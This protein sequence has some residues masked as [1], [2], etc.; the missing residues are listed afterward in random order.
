MVESTPLVDPL[1]SEPTEPT[2]SQTNNSS[3][4]YPT[5]AADLLSWDYVGTIA[6]KMKKKKKAKKA[7]VKD[8]W[9]EPV[10]NFAYEVDRPLYK[11]GPNWAFK[12]YKDNLLEKVSN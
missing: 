3:V 12:D 8:K 10:Q 6:S 4:E 7:P 2:T 11:A 5:I 1:P 9:D